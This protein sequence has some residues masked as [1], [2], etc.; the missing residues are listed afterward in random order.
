MFNTIKKIT[1]LMLF[2]VALLWIVV[3]TLAQQSQT[4]IVMPEGTPPVATI[5]ENIVLLVYN[6]TYLPFAAG[7]VLVA[8]AFSKRIP[9]LKSVS[10]SVLSLWW[11]VLLWAIWI[12]ATQAGFGG[13]FENLLTGLTTIG[14]AML[15]ITLTPMA[16]GKLYETANAQRVAIIGYKRPLTMTDAAAM[17]YKPTVPVTEAFVDGDLSSNG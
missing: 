2:I 13:L 10:S 17:A 11:T 16:A 5:L 8:T 6:A 15:G 1:M 14:A 9:F 3:P 4:V 12:V 7:M